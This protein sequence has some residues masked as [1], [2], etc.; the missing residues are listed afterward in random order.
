MPHGYE[1]AIDHFVFDLAASGVP[2]YGQGDSLGLGP[3]NDEQQVQIMLRA[4][5]LNGDEISNTF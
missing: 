5:N 1:R 2:S 4:F 3:F